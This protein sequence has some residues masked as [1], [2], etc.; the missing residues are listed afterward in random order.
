[1]SGLSNETDRDVVENRATASNGDAGHRG[2]GTLFYLNI[3]RGPNSFSTLQIYTREWYPTGNEIS[4]EVGNEVSNEVSFSPATKKPLGRLQ[5]LPAELRHIIYDFALCD[6]KSI[7]FHLDKARWPE[8]RPD[9]SVPALAHVCQEMRYYAMSKYMLVYWKGTSVTT[10]I[11]HGSTEPE[12]GSEQPEVTTRSGFGVVHP[13]IYPI[14]I[15]AKTVGSVVDITEDAT[16]IWD[17][18]YKA[19]I[20]KD[21]T[22]QGLSFTPPHKMFWSGWGKIIMTDKSVWVINKRTG[23][24]VWQKDCPKKILV[25]SKCK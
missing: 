12:P 11:S 9:F 17:D 15:L 10:K 8:K 16:V 21:L 20:L 2:P 19:P 18:R 25:F 13:G 23:E 3:R 24:K 22:T 1:M 4:N 14:R 6:S 7:N 5:L